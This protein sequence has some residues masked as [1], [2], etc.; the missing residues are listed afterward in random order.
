MI[1]AKNELCDVKRAFTLSEKHELLFSSTSAIEM[2]L[3]LLYCSLCQWFRGV[4]LQLIQQIVTRVHPV[5]EG[6]MLFGSLELSLTT[7]HT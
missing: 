7:Q 1:K 6:L 2:L 3:S 5:V 4:W